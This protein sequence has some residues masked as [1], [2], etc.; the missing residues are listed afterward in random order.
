MNALHH[1]TLER[2]TTDRGHDRASGDSAPT[3]STY[4]RL[5][6]PAIDRVLGAVLVLLALPVLIACTTAVM[7]SLGRP[8]L[9]RQRRIG[10]NGEP[11]AMVKFRTMHPDRR[12]GVDRRS[13][14]RPGV[15]DRRQTHKHPDDPRLT[16]VGRFLRTW[17][18]DELPQLLHVLTGRMSLVGPRPEIEEIVDKYW[19]WQHRRHEVKPGLTGLW[20]VSERANGALM[21]ECVEVDLAYVDS[22]SPRTDLRIIARTLPSLLGSGRGH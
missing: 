16:R 17:S 14:P 1:T 8:V 15:V 10:L 12:S 21:H 5:I 22:V 9:F 2:V 19:G 6:K 13:T 7:I 4:A 11:F 20:Q 18:L 3:R